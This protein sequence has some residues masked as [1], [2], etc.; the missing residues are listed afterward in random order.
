MSRRPVVHQFTAVL[1]DRDALGQHTLAV[2]DLLRDMGADTM[3]YAAHVHPEV[4]DR[5]RDFRR[6]EDDPAPDLIV[7]QTSIG[8]PVAEY[9]L[10]RR[11]PLVLNYHNMTPAS[12]FD[13]WEPHVAAELDDGRRQLV[14]LCRRARAAI[15]V[16]EYNANELRDLGLDSV[17]VAP[18]LFSALSAHGGADPHTVVSARGGADPHTVV[19]GRGGADP[20]TV[21][22]GRGGADPHTVSGSGSEVGDGS[23]SGSEVGDVPGSAHAATATHA[24]T[25]LFVGR[26]APNKCQQDL[27]G[28]LA[29]VVALGVDARL[30]LVGGV[31]S[32][33]FVE[34]VVGLADRLGVGDR[35][36]V[37]GSVSEAELVGWYSVADVFVSV[38][39]HE[40]FCVPV[41]EAMGFGVPVVAFGAAAVPETV[42]GAG[43]V[44]GEKSVG[45]VAEAVVRVLSDGVVREGLVERGRV[46]AAA[47]GPPVSTERMR[48]VLQPLLDEATS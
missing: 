2:D 24:A 48:A 36:V 27:V 23:G 31:S 47:L 30:V 34:S 45:V 26:L 39:E 20:H 9:V 3:I 7:Y 21:V 32:S 42:G 40:G 6:H 41:V 35:L 5:G 43:V 19:S 1:A 38:S 15:A 22:S 11:E 46:R 25:M 4:K 18:V 33:G 13:P 10:G 12:F 14:R 8:S 28:V 37:A 17:A 44:L 16:S 29:G